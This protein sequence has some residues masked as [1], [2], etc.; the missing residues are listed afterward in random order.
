MY[1]IWDG[2]ATLKFQYIE[3]PDGGYMV[4]NNPVGIGSFTMNDCEAG[5]GSAAFG[6]GNAVNVSNS[7]AS[8]EGIVVSEDN[9]FGVGSYNKTPVENEIFSV[10][11]GTSN[12]DRKTAMRL[13][14]D[15]FMD[16]SGDLTIFSSELSPAQ[17]PFTAKCRSSI[18]ARNMPDNVVMNV[19]Y[20]TFYSNVDVLEDDTYVL[21]YSV[22]GWLTG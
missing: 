20:D 15:G 2:T 4:R 7:F 14:S 16:M 13:L 19:N 22:S 12:D 11:V 10:G 1:Y 3:I 21:T 8:G 17:Y 9:A 18:E 5:T 6:E